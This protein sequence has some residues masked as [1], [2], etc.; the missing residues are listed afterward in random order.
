MK[1]YKLSKPLDKF[2]KKLSKAGITT[3]NVSEAM[4]ISV[5]SL[6]N[7]RNGRSSINQD[8]LVK[9]K[10]YSMRLLLMGGS[11][12]PLKEEYIEAIGTFNY[13]V[14]NILKEIPKIGQK[15]VGIMSNLQKY[16][17]LKM[18]NDLLKSNQLDFVIN[19]DDG[20]IV[21]ID[22]K[23]S[24]ARKLKREYN[25][26]FT[27]NFNLLI[28]FIDEVSRYEIENLS[29]CPLLLDGLREDLFVEFYNNLPHEE[30]FDVSHKISSVAELWLE[31]NLKV[32][33]TQI[34]NWK[35]G[36]DFP[37]E[38]NLKNLKK[39]TGQSGEGAFLT[40]KFSN[41]NFIDMFVPSLKVEADRRYD[42]ETYDET[43]EYFTNILFFYCGDNREVIDLQKNMRENL[44]KDNEST[45]ASSFFTEI[46]NLKASREINQSDN[47]NK[48][49]LEL[50]DY[51]EMNDSAVEYILNKDYKI[52]SYIFTDKNILLLNDFTKKHLDNEQRNALLELVDQL[53]KHQ[54]I[55]WDIL[56]FSTRFSKL[57]N[58]EML[59]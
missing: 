3:K 8:N 31:Q 12:M 4:D 5:H 50:V 2:L 26:K 33:K 6:S 44:I 24:M 42:E 10:A 55:D 51:F 7:W 41:H 57:Y 48:I 1:N 56:K 28:K 16:P 34:V 46:R 49:M 58:S 17:E 9:L 38:E 52:L 43:L 14:D 27:Q 30:D 21:Q 20:S 59:K 40:Y 19:S 39:I 29:E 37:A 13:Y 53:S 32:S 36:N 11:K 47:T 23:I 22:K 25:Q 45:L 15:E 35:K 18:I 54:G